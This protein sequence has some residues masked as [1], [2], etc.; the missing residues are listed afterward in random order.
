[1]PGLTGAGRASLGAVLFWMVV[2]AAAAEQ[3]G[4]G[5]KVG[6]REDAPPFVSLRAGPPPEGITGPGAEYDGFAATICRAVLDALEPG[7]GDVETFP[8]NAG[9]RFTLEDGA[10]RDL[11][12]LCDT[13]SITRE[14]LAFCS[15]SFPYFV[16]GISFASREFRSRIGSV[17]GKRIGLV[18]GTTAVE[19]LNTEWQRRF[20][21][22]PE[23]TQFEDYEQGIEAMTGERIDVL[24]GDQILLEQAIRDA[25]AGFDVSD[26]IISTELYGLCINPDRPDLL[27]VTNDTL[28]ELY[29]SGQ[30]YSVLSEYFEGRGASRFL[31]TL[32]SLYAV[33]EN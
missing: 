6:F 25:D 22:Q 26:D 2:S 30:I 14:R 29:G 16:T 10:P 33:P 15:F 1:M 19:R 21:D 17:E 23:I 18:G 5:L 32:Y 12:I 31:V 11:D 27:R 9:D 13:T 7:I 20:G 4:Q 24:F 8:V 28:A 3:T